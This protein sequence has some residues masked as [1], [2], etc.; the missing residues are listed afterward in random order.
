MWD[1]YLLFFLYYISIPKNS[2][3]PVSFFLLHSCGKNVVFWYGTHF[4]TPGIV[5]PGKISRYLLH[6]GQN[7][8]LAIYILEI[9]SIRA[10]WK[11]YIYLRKL[12]CEDFTLPQKNN[13]NKLAGDSYYIS[14][15]AE[16]AASEALFL[17][18][19]IV[20]GSF[21]SRSQLEMHSAIK[22]LVQKPTT[23][24][25]RIRHDMTHANKDMTSFYRW[26]VT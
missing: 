4:V 20:R 25:P 13:F 1:F 3:F 23:T 2:L 12:T 24:K 15:V 9:K 8:K 26:F 16:C 10:Q 19:H 7:L 21:E 17:R 6:S 14:A 11:L 5:R 22:Y 18:R